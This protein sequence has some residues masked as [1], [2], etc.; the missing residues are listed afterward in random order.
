MHHQ[1][2]GSGGSRK[3]NNSCT[4][5]RQHRRAQWQIMRIRC[6]NMPAFDGNAVMVELR[7]K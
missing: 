3:H 7:Q 1:R 5:L 4:R 6:A 2:F